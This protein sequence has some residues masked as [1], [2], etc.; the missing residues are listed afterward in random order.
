MIDAVLSLAYAAPGEHACAADLWD[1][2]ER[3]ARESRFVD[4]YLQRLLDAFGLGAP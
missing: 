2:A 1:R 3:V 4:P